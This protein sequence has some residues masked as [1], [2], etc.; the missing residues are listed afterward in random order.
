VSTGTFGCA[1]KISFKTTTTQSKN[2][3]AI[4]SERP[5]STLPMREN[6]NSITLESLRQLLQFA[7]NIPEFLQ[8]FFDH[9]FT[10]DPDVFF[11]ACVQFFNEGST[12]ERKR[13]TISSRYLEGDA[14]R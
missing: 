11:D 3:T 8:T 4:S 2:D 12:S 13:L 5:I 1:Q 6:E 10:D 9:R 14:A 7:A